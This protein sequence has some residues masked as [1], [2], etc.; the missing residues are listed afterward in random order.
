[1]DIGKCLENLE[2]ILENE[3]VDLEELMK[4]VQVKISQYK[5]LEI[6]FEEVLKFLY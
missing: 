4:R 1:M 3:S 2:K 5:K 6:K